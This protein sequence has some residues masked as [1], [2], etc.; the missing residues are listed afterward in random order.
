MKLTAPAANATF[1]IT[2]APAWPSIAFETDA[3]GPHTWHW[4]LAWGTFKKS[5]TDTTRPVQICSPN[6]EYEAPPAVIQC[7]LLKHDRVD[8]A[9][10]F[11]RFAEHDAFVAQLAQQRS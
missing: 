11:S 3:G 5:G 8:L 4:S 1:T 6:S 7:F 9:M 2:S 10:E